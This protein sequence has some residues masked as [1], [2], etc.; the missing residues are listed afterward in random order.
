M[1]K[2]IPFKKEIVFKTNLAEVTS[3][4]LEHSLHVEK[5]QL[6]TG[7]FEVSGEYKISDNSATTDIFS[8]ELP[9]D[10]EMD[11]RYDLSDCAVDIHDFYYEIINSS[12]LSVNIEVSVSNFKERPLIEPIEE[13]P[14]MEIKR[15]IAPLEAD[16]VR[17][18]KQEEVSPMM[19]REVVAP[20][21]SV[22]EPRCIEEEIEDDLPSKRVANL[23]DSFDEASET[24]TTYKIYIVREGDTLESILEKY[25]TTKEELE[26]YNQL[27]EL[28][29]GMKLIIPARANEESN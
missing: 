18:E 12:I 22:S 6:I 16:L 27:S 25:S 20:V 29:L 26:P 1:K 2:I 5:E 8:F 17:E 7:Q 23:F 28:Q 10:I 13:E 14:M 3:I 24:Y 11:E 21:T 19:E 4:S 9:F 15:E